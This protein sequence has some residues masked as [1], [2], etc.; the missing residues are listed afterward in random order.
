V[1][2]NDADSGFQHVLY[3]LVHFFT[4]AI[5]FLIEKRTFVCYTAFLEPDEQIK[6]QLTRD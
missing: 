1:V 6:P 5:Y 4:K 2:E 3:I